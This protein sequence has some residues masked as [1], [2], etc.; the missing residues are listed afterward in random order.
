MKV[1]LCDAHPEWA[2]TFKALLQVEGH[3]ASWVK[4]DDIDPAR[5]AAATPDVLFYNCEFNGITYC[6]ERLIA[7]KRDPVC[8]TIPVILL[9]TNETEALR[10]LSKARLEVEFVL[11]LPFTLGQLRN[12][13]KTVEARLH[14]QAN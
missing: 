10:A 6:M 11:C 7:L 1:M 14:V 5:I 12:A 13:L 8:K 2:K 4:C 3:Q 9:C